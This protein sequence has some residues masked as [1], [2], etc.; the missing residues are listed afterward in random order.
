MC[1]GEERRGSAT[2]Q[3]PC[4]DLNPLDGR[5]P[6]HPF[7]TPLK[8][9]AQPTQTPLTRIT[10][11]TLA[12]VLPRR[13]RL[14]RLLPRPV[15]R[16]ASPHMPYVVALLS[17]HLR[18]HLFV[19]GEHREIG[20][21]VDVAGAAAAGGG[22]GCGSPRGG[23]GVGGDFGERD[24]RCGAGGGGDFVGVASAAAAAVD[25]VVWEGGGVGFGDLVG[26]FCSW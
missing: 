26:H 16:A 11:H 1:T 23:G 18:V 24:G 20:H 13:F 10:L 3:V 2:A 19:E 14:Q 12:A 22:F 5:S 21:G 9:T 17:P 15:S 7:S 6:P 8:S 25:V 4:L